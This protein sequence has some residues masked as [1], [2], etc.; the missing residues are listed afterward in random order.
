MVAIYV[1]YISVIKKHDNI[2]IDIDEIK[3]FSSTLDLD[4]V[5]L[6]T[7]KLMCSSNIK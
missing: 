7:K 2:L 4:F 1:F 3:S 6:N 5:L